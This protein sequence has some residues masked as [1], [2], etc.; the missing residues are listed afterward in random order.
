VVAD[1]D[2]AFVAEALALLPD[3]PYDDES[4]ADWTAEVRERTGRKGKAL[5][6]P[7]RKA[8]TGM[9]KGPDMAGVLALMQTRPALPSAG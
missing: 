6:M 1:E 5:F 8:L 4:W 3:P 2:R 7:L 9:E